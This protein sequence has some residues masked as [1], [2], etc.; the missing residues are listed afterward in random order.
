VPLCF[1][2][3]A[4]GHQCHLKG[5]ISFAKAVLL[6]AYLA[7]TPVLVGDASFFCIAVPVTTANFEHLF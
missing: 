2:A 4:A 6:I 3:A 5:V 7:V 1:L